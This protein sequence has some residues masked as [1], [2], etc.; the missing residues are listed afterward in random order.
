MKKWISLFLALAM[1]SAFGVSLADAAYPV[2]NAQ[3]ITLTFGKIAQTQITSQ[4]DSLQDTPLMQEYMRA[5]GIQIEVVAPA[6]NTAMNLLFASGSMPDMVYYGWNNYAGGIAKAVS[7]GIVLPLNDLL[8]A[9]APDYKAQINKNEDYRRGTMTNSG[10]VYGFAFIRDHKDLLT[11]SGPIIRSDWLRKCGLEVPQTVTEFY[12]ALVAFR[13][14]CGATAPLSIGPGSLA[15]DNSA[16][17]IVGAFGLPQTGF[18]RE[19][20]TVKYG[21]YDARLKDAY[22]FLNKL[23]AEGL[24]DSN[25]AT[26]DSATVNSNLYNGISGVVTGSLGS[27]IGNHLTAMKDD[28]EFDLAGMNYLVADAQKGEKP[29][30][31]HTDFPVMHY[32][33]VITTNCKHP[34]LA[35]Q[36]LNYGYTDAGRMLLNFGIEGES[37]EMVDGYPTFTEEVVNNSEG[38]SMQYALAKYTFSWDGG[39]MMQDERYIYQYAGRPQQQAA[40]AT[41]SDT[42]KAEFMMPAVAVSDNQS[43]RFSSLNSDISTYVAEMRI[44][45]ITGEESLENFDAYLNKLKAMNVEEL[46]A[47]EQAAYDAYMAR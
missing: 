27:G 39:N 7:D 40:L 28:P 24:L 43:A 22:A 32:A 38:L 42:L 46:I 23:Y 11:S 26:V 10:D 2:E 4:Y 8:D 14:L 5:T 12:E 44:K 41:W 29:I 1:L 47:I 15:G 13:D 37:Y 36:F 30:S 21:F 25:F 6:D 35:A 20:D 18:Y 31:G 16:S 3:G 9:Y 34:E 19:G 33:T 17:F 45:F